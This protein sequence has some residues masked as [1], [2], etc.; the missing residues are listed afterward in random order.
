M[1]WYFFCLITG[2]RRSEHMTPVLCDLNWL[3]VRQRITFKTAIL[4]FKCL[5]DM[6]PQYL[7]TYCKPVSAC[8]DRRHP[9]SVPSSL[10]TVPRTSTNYGDS[11]CD[12]AGPRVWNSLRAQL[13]SLDTLDTFQHK[14]MTFLLTQ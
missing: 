4:M 11:S 12:V 9:R 7:Q 1:L 10:L 14:L 8:T 3:L 13:L 6:N 5:H 2:A